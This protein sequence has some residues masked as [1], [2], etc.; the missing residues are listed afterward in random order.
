MTTHS[1][2]FFF[3]DRLLKF[4]A[5]VLGQ[6]GRRCVYVCM[7]AFQGAGAKEKPIM[8]TWNKALIHIFHC[9]VKQLV[10]TKAFG[11]LSSD[12]AAMGPFFP[13]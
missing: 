10:T 2:I 3:L 1:Q 4:K 9:P 5:F 6:E 7:F 13:R 8:C 12:P 11:A